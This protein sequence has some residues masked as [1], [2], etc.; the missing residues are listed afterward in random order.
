MTIEE[1]GELI[2]FDIKSL[3]TSVPVPDAI[4][5]ITKLVTDDDDFECRAGVSRE[6][7]VEMMWVCL[8]STYFQQRSEHYELTDRLAMSSPFSP[9]VAIYGVVRGNSA[10]T[11]SESTKGW[12]RFWG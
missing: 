6:T 2:S 10:E 5:A 7:L 12:H 4:V 3:F 11:F 9:A 1:D 8:S